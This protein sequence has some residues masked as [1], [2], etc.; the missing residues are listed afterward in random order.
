LTGD[1]ATAITAGKAHTCVVLSQGRVSCWGWNK[2]GQLGTGRNV[3]E[4]TPTELKLN[5]G[6][7]SERKIW[8]GKTERSERRGRVREGK[9]A[10]RKRRREGKNAG[11]QF[12][13]QQCLRSQ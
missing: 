12:F 10:G 3:L 5:S 4:Q 11:R 2:F 1:Y 7:A 6:A 8:K 9:A 13:G